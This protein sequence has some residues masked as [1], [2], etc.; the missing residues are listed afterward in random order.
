MPRKA[1]YYEIFAVSLAAILLEISYT[2]IFSFKVWYYFTYLIIGIALMGLGTGGVLVAVSRRL[3]QADT[4]RLIPRLCIIGG[5]SVLCGYLSIARTQLNISILTSEPIEIL[6]LAGICLLLTIPFLI[7]GIIIS[8][9]LSSRP[10]IAGRLYGADLLGAA[11]GCIACIPLLVLLDPPRTVMVS[12]LIFALGGL[13]LALPSRLVSGATILIGLMLTIPIAMASVLPDPIVDKG[14]SFRGSR[15]DDHVLFSK[16]HPVFRVDVTCLENNDD[17]YLLSHD[18]Q[19]GSALHRFSGDFSDIDY[20]NSDVRSLP[21]EVLPEHPK[22][23]IIGAAGGQEILA[24]LL[25]EASHVTGVELNPVTVSLL[26]DIFAEYSG[27]LDKNPRVTLINGEGRW[28]LKRDKGKY[29][30]IWFVAPDSYAAMNASS[31]AGFVLAESYLYTV[32]MLRESLKHLTENGMICAQFGEFNYDNKPNRTARYVATARRA[33][34][35][36][37]AGNFEHHII[38]G[39]RSGVLLGMNMSTVLV[40]SSPFS[41]GQIKSFK[42]KSGEIEGSTVRYL[43]SRTPDSTPVNQV[44]TL[45][46]SQLAHWYKEYPYEVD[47]IYDDSPYFWHFARFRNALLSPLDFGNTFVDREDSIAERVSFALLV[48]VTSF[49][50]FFLLLPFAAIYRTWSKIPRKLQA[51]VYFASLGLGFMFIE[52]SLIQMLTLFLGYPT[53]SL[54]VTLFGLLLFSGLGSLTSERYAAHRNRALGILLAVLFGLILFYQFCLPFVVDRFVGY[55]FAFRLILTIAMLAPLGL[56]LGSFMPIGLMTVA[57]T[58]PHK[59]EYVAWAWAV[60]GFFSVMASIL[61]TILAMI[62]GFKLVLLLAVA[63]YAAGVLSLTR[64]PEE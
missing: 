47:P 27:H 15:K 54:S 9:I 41:L 5:V 42:E 60:N 2:R 4:D 55:P 61:S 11:L 1:F 10:E 13:R 46:E 16:W 64:F 22:V 35:E 56:C 62:F 34:A 38:V 58:T 63:I 25:F 45:D 50:A 8:T 44:I 24:S 7:T 51:G 21:F 52:M 3:R 30:L 49:A 12:G 18:G 33:F 20:L 29:D 39:S 32:E 26:T 6:K 28:F 59:R 53:H 14:K 36:Q 37:R 19:V 57:R 31:A 40:A 43:P 17:I 48:I 23:L